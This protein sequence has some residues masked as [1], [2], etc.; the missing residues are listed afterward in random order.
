M[1]LEI[2]VDIKAALTITLGALHIGL[3]L[4]CY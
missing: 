4:D 2:I 3:L 1:T